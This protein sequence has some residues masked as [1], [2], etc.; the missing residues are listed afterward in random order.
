MR[1]AH[2]TQLY[3]A[4]ELCLPAGLVQIFDCFT[5]IF[6]LTP[7]VKSF[8]STVCVFYKSTEKC[9]KPATFGFLVSR[10]IVT[11]RVVRRSCSVD[12]IDLRA[13]VVSNACHLTLLSPL[14][15]AALLR[16]T[17]RRT[18]FSLREWR[19][20]VAD[21]KKVTACEPAVRTCDGCLYTVLASPVGL[22]LILNLGGYGLSPF[23]HSEVE[24]R[25][26]TQGE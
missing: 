1:I 24:V 13:C 17:F 2:A 7:R 12:N 4:F 26:F 23:L 14:S 5:S 15:F 6:G 11:H 16:R 3:L 20:I 9:S 19:W 8:C 25:H 22:L 10:S 21:L 18:D